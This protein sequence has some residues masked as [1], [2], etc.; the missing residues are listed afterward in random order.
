SVREMGVELPAAKLLS[1]MP[2]TAPGSRREARL[3]TNC[4]SPLFFTWDHQNPANAAL[5][6]PGTLSR[7]TASDLRKTA[8]PGGMGFSRAISSTGSL[9]SRAYT[10]LASRAMYCV[11]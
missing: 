8:F 10:R 3:R 6:P 7:E 5:Q 11:Q 4:A 1:R 2:T 9:M